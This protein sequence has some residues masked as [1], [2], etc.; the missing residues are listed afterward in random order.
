MSNPKKKEQIRE[1]NEFN[2]DSEDPDKQRAR[3]TS[4]VPVPLSSESTKK[5]KKLR[6]KISKSSFATAKF[7]TPKIATPTPPKGML[8]DS[9]NPL[10]EEL[11]AN[12][13]HM[14]WIKN[15]MKQWTRNGL[16][17]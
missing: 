14:T 9:T 6:I 4:M 12:P 2:H 1:L 16:N 10:L 7:T 3:L 8:G 11:N 13:D 5:P 15:L 17:I